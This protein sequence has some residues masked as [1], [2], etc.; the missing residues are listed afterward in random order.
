MRSN[1]LLFILF[2]WAMTSRAQH[3][4]FYFEKLL[5]ESAE[6]PIDV[7]VENPGFSWV[8]K[9]ALPGGYQKR[10]RIRVGT[11]SAGLEKG[12]AL[13][14]DSGWK[15]SD[16]TLHH[17]YQG[18][19][20]KSNGRYFWTVEIENTQGRK[21]KSGVQGFS[22]AILKP[23]EWKAQW[24]GSKTA[25]S[26]RPPNG[27]FKDRKEES[28]LGKDSVVHEGRSLRLRKEYTLSRKVKTARIFVTGLG[29]YELY[30]NGGKVGNKVLSPAKTN[31]TK[32]VLYDTYD[33]TRLL[34]PGIN[35]L[36]IQ[37]GNGWY[38]PYKRWW[39]EYRMQWFGAQ[40]ALLQLHI[41]YEDGTE[42]IKG[43]DETWRTAPGPLLFNCI[44]DGEIYD[45]GLETAGWSEPFFEESGWSPARV[46]DE[47]GGALLAQRMPALEVIETRKP[48]TVLRPG[49]DTL[50]YDFGQ[51][52][53]GWVKIRVKGKKGAK[54]T[55]R[56]AEDIQENGALDVSSNEGAKA[57]ATYIIGSDKAET[58]E[59][60]F[61]Y[62]GF[63]YAE[64]TGEP[65]S[66]QVLDVE[67][68]VVH[69]ANSP[70]GTF[71]CGNELVNKIHQAT[72]WSQRSNMLG[73]PMD[74]PQRDERLGWLGDAQV[75]AEEGMF[76]F[77]LNLYNR[78]W[79]SGI[80]ENQ[81]PL[82]GDIP[83]ISP[84]P[85]IKDDG[86]EWS[87]TFLLMTWQH[88]LYYGD[89]GILRENYPAMKRYM[90]FLDSIAVDYIVPMGWI[91]D[92]GSMVKGWKEGEP[93]SVPTAF[94]Y[95]NA[96]LLVKVAALL[97][98]RADQERF[99]SLAQRIRQAFTKHFFDPASSNYNDGSQMANSFPLYIGLEETQHREAI[100]RN[101]TEDI[102][103]KNATHLT[104]GVLGTKY[105]MDALAKYG[106]QDIVW[107]LVT[108]TSPPSWHEMMKRYT[109]VC[110]FWTLKQSKNHVMMGSIDAWFYKELAGIQGY[111]ES[112]AFKKFVL[113]P[114]FPPGLSH[115]K[116]SF[117]SPRGTIESSWQLSPLGYELNVVIPFNTT[118]YL[119][120]PAGNYSVRD[121]TKKLRRS[122]VNTG[123]GFQRLTL[124][125]GSYQLE[126]IRK[127]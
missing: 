53:A 31:Y 27:F 78:N 21:I 22:T 58:Y 55:L 117:T 36:G 49:S 103:V 121:K 51:N 56:F 2:F 24:I 50:V 30:V 96:R 10:F 105:M 68:R 89:I 59:P 57:T 18:K 113:K 67:G 16:E 48:V 114:Y 7:D 124:E 47:P 108:Q 88:Y 122:A 112:P 75:T 73:Y 33:V 17:R 35:A 71:E 12:H 64:I 115:V 69:S 99:H 40:K 95:L 77:D 87:S 41:T 65:Q 126:V 25:S 82:T 102:L 34:R 70:T 106:R 116:A 93:K 6:Q 107:A 32:Q 104:T 52:F 85:Y 28:Y 29:L 79:L 14:W 15:L 26:V 9:D 74:C 61:T 81:H 45:A 80:R 37:L 100:L 60:R 91:G 94:Y 20:L 13:V 39:K 23:T 111:D 90:A 101:L 83:I 1:F 66:F 46:V 72:V 92:W 120:L 119:A 97:G 109:T 84:R 118:A 76:N 38:N 44:Y 123:D 125:P 42:E 127:E 62:F 110:E 63:R 54:V 5:C 11:D 3:P 43:T 98:E 8:V 19:E 86:V 4:G